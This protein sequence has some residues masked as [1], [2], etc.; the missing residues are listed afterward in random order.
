MIKN[1][2]WIAAALLL[3]VAPPL[4]AQDSKVEDRE[5]SPRDTE[6]VVERTRSGV[7][8]VRERVRRAIRLPEVVQE[9]KDAGV[10]EEQ[11]RDVLES[12][13]TRG[14]PAGDVGQI[15]EVENEAIRQGGNPD[16]FGAAVQQM[17]ASGLRGREL[18]EAIHAEQYARGMKKPKRDKAYKGR[19][20]GKG[21]SHGDE[22]GHDDYDEDRFDDDED[23]DEDDDPKSKGKSKPNKERGK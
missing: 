16:N 4:A 21:K 7:E 20:K 1:W 2:I 15:L 13:R 5:P 3:L 19:G 14:I 8:R 12:A 11:V 18:A 6:D 17:K 23:E 10:S 22:R 9:S